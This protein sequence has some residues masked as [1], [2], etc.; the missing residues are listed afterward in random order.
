MST[1]LPRDLPADRFHGGVRAVALLLWLGAIIVVFIVLRL[2]AGL[3]FDNLG[4][5]GL[6]ILVVLAVVLAQPLAFWGERLLVQRWPSGRALRLEPNALEWRDRAAVTRLELGHNL[7]YWRWRFVVKK[8]RGGRIQAGHHLFAVRVVQGDSEVSV[9]TFLPPAAA[10]ALSKRY[11]FYELRRPNDPAKAALGGRDAVY[12]AA[13][14]VRW[15]SGAELDPGDFETLLQH[16]GA[17]AP[18]FARAPASNLLT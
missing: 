17:S 7:S 18:D 14:D 6:L 11:S 9:Y 16:L 3:V 10:E 12:L 1:S 13:E 5:L 15:A 2:L 4:G 8:R